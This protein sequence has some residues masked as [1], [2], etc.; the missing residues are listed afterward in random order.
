VIT[1]KK[2]L[3][4]NKNYSFSAYSYNDDND[5]LKYNFSWGDGSFNQTDFVDNGTNVERMHSWKTRGAYTIKVSVTDENNATSSNTLDVYVDVIEYIK[6]GL[7]GYLLDEDED[8]TYDIFNNNQTGNETIV[9]FQAG[10]YKIDID[11]DG[12]WDYDYNPIDKTIKEI[13]KETK[14]DSNV[15]YY[16]FA[17]IFVTLASLVIIV[18][19]LRRS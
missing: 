8:G 4:I 5:S 3:N 16:I 14:E 13:E 19:F 11:D 6:N 12:S 17:L 15:L 1:G 10:F 2:V 9:G 7:D 18:I